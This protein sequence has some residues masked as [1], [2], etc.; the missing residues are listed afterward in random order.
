MVSPHLANAILFEEPARSNLHA[1][2]AGHVMHSTECPA[3][4]PCLVLH[5][6]LQPWLGSYGIC[7]VCQLH[8][9]KTV[10]IK[11]T[12]LGSLRGSALASHSVGG[13]GNIAGAWICRNRKQMRALWDSTTF[14]LHVMCVCARPLQHSTCGSSQQLPNWSRVAPGLYAIHSRWLKGGCLS[15]KDECPTVEQ[16]PKESPNSDRQA[17]QSWI[18]CWIGVFDLWFSISTKLPDATSIQ[19]YMH[20]VQVWSSRTQKMWSFRSRLLRNQVP[21]LLNFSPVF[22]LAFGSKMILRE[23]RNTRN[24]RDCL[25]WKSTELHAPNALILRM[26][27]NLP[28]SYGQMG[29][30]NRR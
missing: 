20:T 30:V 6:T 26:A 11:I 10:R 19:T 28:Q 13:S 27:P 1:V 12:A 17:E 24:A 23:K 8:F 22:Q 29:P 3:S 4:A 15:C 2:H 21:D 14:F 25:W 7:H 18:T 5:W 9:L 16:H